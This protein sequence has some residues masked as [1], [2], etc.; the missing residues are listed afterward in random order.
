MDSSAPKPEKRSSLRFDTLFPVVMSAEEY[1]SHR[2]IDR[3]IS[4]GGM[5]LQTP[6][7]LPLGA[8]IRVHFAMEGGQGEIVARAQIVTRPG[9]I[10]YISDLFTEPRSRRRG[11]ARALIQRL[12]QCA[13]DSGA[14]RCLL[15][16]SL[17]T[18]EIGLYEKHGYQGLIPMVLLIPDRTPP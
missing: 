3:N 10:A 6:E 5:F 11:L 1:G 17:M 2:C 7:P 8:T 9:G 12:H 15:V 14:T 13:T 4:V 16:P 18:R